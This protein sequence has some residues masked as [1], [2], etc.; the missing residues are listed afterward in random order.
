MLGLAIIIVGICVMFGLFSYSYYL[1]RE[2]RNDPMLGVYLPIAIFGGLGL[3][4]T[5]VKLE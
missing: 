1:Y 2:N 5:G 3:I 4:F